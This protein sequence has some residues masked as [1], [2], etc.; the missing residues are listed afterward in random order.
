M[1][2]EHG[3][4]VLALLNHESWASVHAYSA[5]DFGFKLA[6]DG[7]APRDCLTIASQF[8]RQLNV[9]VALPDERTL[10]V[11]AFI[12]CGPDGIEFDIACDDA[13]PDGLTWRKIEI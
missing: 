2:D 12:A 13:E 5:G 1:P 8:A 4:K 6:L 9:L 10:A 11:T 7:R 3:K